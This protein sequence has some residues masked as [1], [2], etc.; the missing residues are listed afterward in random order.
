MRKHYRILIVDDHPHA[1]EAIR[2]MLEI[3]PSFEL[4][5]EASNGFVAFDLCGRLLPDLVLMDI[6]MPDVNGLDATRQIKEAYPFI[7]VV[8][9]SVSDDI[10]DLFS[11]IQVGAQGYLL[12]NMDPEEWLTYLHSLIEGK[13]DVS[14]QMAGRMLY[15]F[16]E[17]LSPD[18]PELSVLT[19]RETEI[20]QYVA[21]GDTNR[22][23][24]EKLC[25]TENTVKN[26]IKNLLEKLNLENRVQLASYAVRKGL[27]RSKK[28]MK[29]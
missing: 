20:L 26:H 3:D 12:K 24:A 29:G 16:R 13:M 22:Q 21:C 25:I 6:N 28:E 18:E 8:I 1:R 2:S 27:T 23:I 15:Q 4:V 11:A 14:R 5:G 7:K 9:L 17:G 10:K 19:P